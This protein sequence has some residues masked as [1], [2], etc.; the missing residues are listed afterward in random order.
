MPPIELSEKERRDLEEAGRLHYWKNEP[1]IDQLIPVPDEAPLT[2]CPW[3][4]EEYKISE[5]D[6]D[7]YYE[8][9]VIETPDAP[10]GVYRHKKC[11]HLVSFGGFSD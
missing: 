1:V 4:G 6:P 9:I 7:T 3:C 8:T 10:H 11:G 2:E 5:D